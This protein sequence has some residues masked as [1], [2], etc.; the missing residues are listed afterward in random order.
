M[1][2]EKSKNPKRV[3]IIYK[4]KRVSLPAECLKGLKGAQRTKMIK[5]TI[6]GPRKKKK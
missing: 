3:N 2:A 4:G 1:K 5:M 6:E